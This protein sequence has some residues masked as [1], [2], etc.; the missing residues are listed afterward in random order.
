[1][2]E[3]ITPS[4]NKVMGKVRENLVSMHKAHTLSWGQ[5]KSRKPPPKIR[6]TEIKLDGEATNILVNEI[7]KVCH[8]I[9]K[10]C[11]KTVCEMTPD[12]IPTASYR[13]IT[14]NAMAN[15]VHTAFF[16]LTRHCKYRYILKQ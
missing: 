10:R 16:S 8:D 4:S 12:R 5:T 6:L 1:M 2:Q 14:I 11:K 3:L 13:C 7:K 9:F 15:Y